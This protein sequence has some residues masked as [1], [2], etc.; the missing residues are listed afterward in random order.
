[1]EQLDRHEFR[2]ER[3]FPLESR[4]SP[5]YDACLRCDKWEMSGELGFAPADPRTLPIII[6]TGWC[7]GSRRR[8]ADP[9]TF[10]SILG[11]PRP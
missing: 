3:S 8:R 7:A 6:T 9:G 11:R 2:R 5:R 1:M 10:A 4:S